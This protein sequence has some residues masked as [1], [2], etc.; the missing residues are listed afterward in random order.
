MDG[1]ISSFQMVP[2]VP[3]RGGTYLIT[4]ADKPMPVCAAPDSVVSEASYCYPVRDQE[5]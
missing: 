3:M 4:S 2:K 5:I 1:A